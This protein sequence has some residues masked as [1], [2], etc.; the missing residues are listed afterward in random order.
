MV[1]ILYYWWE[2]WGPKR[3]RAWPNSVHW[4]LN[5]Q[6]LNYSKLSVKPMLLMLCM[7]LAYTP[8]FFVIKIIKGICHPTAFTDTN[9]LSFN[10]DTPQLASLACS[11]KDWASF[12]K[13][14][15]VKWEENVNFEIVVLFQHNPEATSLLPRGKIMD[16]NI[17][18]YTAFLKTKT[19]NYFSIIFQKYI[20]S[21]KDGYKHNSGVLIQSMSILSQTL[22]VKTSLPKDLTRKDKKKAAN[23]LKCKYQEK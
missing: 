3:L 14:G 5:D 20:I 18:K 4:Q 23:L 13:R 11:L 21:T 10:K 16:T 1:I 22:K 2:N 19:L 9:V 17:H 7:L 15:Q 8:T 6:D 12:T